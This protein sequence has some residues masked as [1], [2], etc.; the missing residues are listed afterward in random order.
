MT[1]PKY[2][3]VPNAPKHHYLEIY[4]RRKRY[5]EIEKRD[6]IRT[7]EK[8]IDS[9]NANRQLQIGPIQEPK[10]RISESELYG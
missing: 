1:F 5:I 10:A 8:V 9:T 6:K 3:K 7:P 4:T 2:W